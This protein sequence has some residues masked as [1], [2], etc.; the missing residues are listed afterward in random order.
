MNE[1]IQLSTKVTSV[2]N[3]IDRYENAD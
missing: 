3:I 1:M 2:Q